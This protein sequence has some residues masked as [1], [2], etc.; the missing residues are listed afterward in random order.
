MDPVTHVVRWRDASGAGL[1]HLVVQDLQARIV[2]KSVLIHGDQ[3]AAASYC[4]E[5]D[6]AWHFRHALIEIVGGARLDIA[7]NPP[8]GWT[9]NGEPLVGFEQAYEIDFVATPFTNTL[10]IRRLNLSIAQSAEIVTAWIDFPSLTLMP[11]PQRYTRLAAR[12]YR[13]ES[14]DTDFTRELEVDGE[15][16]VLDYPGLFVRE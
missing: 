4:V 9:S 5:C 11:D 2:A 6:A 10:A 12:T 16:L 14:L 1:E 13:F 8:S 7:F 3:R 15:G